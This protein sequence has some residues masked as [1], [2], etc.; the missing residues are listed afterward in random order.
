MET[1]ETLTFAT[2]CI[3]VFIP[4]YITIFA[5]KVAL[6]ILLGISVG[7]LFYFYTSWSFFLIYLGGLVFALLF[8]YLL[9]LD[10]HHQSPQDIA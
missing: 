8:G 7:V 6:R 4:L 1:V 5:K 10:D 2:V 3:T 9:D